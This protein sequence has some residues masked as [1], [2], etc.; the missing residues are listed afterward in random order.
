[1]A[2]TTAGATDT[3]KK[4]T[5][6]DVINRSRQYTSSMAA[7]ASQDDVPPTVTET[8]A[9]ETADAEPVAET[10]TEALSQD[11][12]PVV[13]EIPAAEAVLEPEAE[14]HEALAPEVQEILNRRIGK[15]TAKTKEAVE[16]AEAKAAVAE[17]KTKELEA[18]LAEKATIPAETAEDVPH[19]TID[20][21][22]VN[23]PEHPASRARQKAEM[24]LAAIAA[25]DPGYAE[26]Q[27]RQE[28]VRLE[29][30]TPGNMI[31]YL[32]SVKTGA[33]QAEQKFF[34]SYQTN[35]A[36]AVKLYPEIKDGRTKLYAAAKAELDANPELFNKPNWPL[37]AAHI[38]AAKVGRGTQAAAPAAVVKPTL[39][40]KSKAVPVK[41]P[42]KTGGAAPAN[43]GRKS[44][45][46]VQ[47]KDFLLS[48]DRETRV[49][50]L[51]DKLNEGNGLIGPTT[52]AEEVP[53]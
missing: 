27:L 50:W 5:V 40:T 39:P 14:E 10:V 51:Q 35:L 26:R 20:A 4:T 47:P 1:M 31:E 36:E 33:Q 48:N 22:P 32:T 9:P 34:A 44:G 13:E 11:Q 43:A 37:L 18:K 42:V 19:G 17:A 15:M 53:R 2:S 21:G 7:Y 6:A 3:P 52:S 25:N 24:C 41:I 8:A 49:Q 38:A 16:A 45:T 12:P 30:F 46:S 23:V 29:E 28:N